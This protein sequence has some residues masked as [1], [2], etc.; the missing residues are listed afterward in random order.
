MGI[1][2]KLELMTPGGSPWTP[3]CLDL[4]IQARPHILRPLHAYRVAALGRVPLPTPFPIYQLVPKTPTEADSS[5]CG[6]RKNK[7]ESDSVL[8]TTGY[9]VCCY[10]PM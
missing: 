1:P 7:A 2:T 10:P 6:R 8:H 5:V 3:L 9:K 4:R